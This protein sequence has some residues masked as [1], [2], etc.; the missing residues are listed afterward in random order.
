[1]SAKATKPATDEKAEEEETK[2]EF[3]DLPGVGAT[4]AEK[5]R[6]AGYGDMMELAVASPDDIAAAADIGEGIAQ[7]IIVEARKRAKVG[8]FESGTDI[9]ERRKRIG[10]VTTM[11]KNLDELLG[12]GIETQAITEVYGA[13]GSGKCTHPGTPVLY[14]NDSVAHLEPI[15]EIYAKYAAKFGEIPFD[16][17]WAVPVD[18]VQVAGLTESGVQRVRASHL[19]R[20]KVARL[21][22]IKTARGRTL[23]ITPPHKLV[24]ITTEGVSWVPAAKLAPGC[25][26]ATPRTLQAR[27][28]ED[29]PN[30]VDEDDAFFLGLY[31]SEG[32]PIGITNTD[33]R[34]IKWVE[35]YIEG[36][37]GHSPRVSVGHGRPLPAFRVLL[38]KPVRTFL[39]DLATQRSATKR[40]PASVLGGSDGVVRSFLAGYIEGDG[41]IQPLHTEVDTASAGLARDV[42]YLFAR[43]GIQSST[44]VRQVK[45]KP[46]WRVSVV[47][48]DRSRI[49]SLPLRF[50][51]WPSTLPYTSA[52]G[53]PTPTI[54][55]LQRIYRQGLG[56]HRGRKQKRVGR[57][58]NRNDRFY[59][60]LVEERTKSDTLNE[61]TFRAIAETFLE[62]RAR[63]ERAQRLTTRLDHLDLREFARLFDL[64]PQAFSAYAERAGISRSVSQNWR[65]RG[66]SP[67]RDLEPL[68]AIM[69]EDLSR[70]ISILS[71]GLAQMKNIHSFAWDIIVSVEHVPY[72]GFVYDLTVPEGH[73]FVAGEMPTI[74]HNTQLALQV[75]S[76]IQLP[77][78]QGGLEG[79]AVWIDTENTFRPERLT[80]MAKAAGLDPAEALKKVHVAHAFNASHQELLVPKAFELARQKPVRLLVVDS[81]TAH[82]RA[83]FLGRGA[84]AERQQ[85]LNRHM[86]ELLRF[87]DVFNAA[88][89]CTNQV[90]S[91]P[92]VLFGDPTG[93][94]GG[95]IVGHTATYRVYM[96]K[97]KPPRR[98]ARLVD[99][100]NLPEGEAIFSVL[101]E[102]I[103]DAG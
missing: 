25:P 79:E 8:G 97:S 93:P 45:G 20:E 11:S 61:A 30:M 98:I 2:V 57:A 21:I 64:L 66:V 50:K 24:S 49:R 51:Q 80:E 84:L 1:M 44:R 63:L 38:R 94:I 68:K 100:P 77:V 42:A 46:Y 33:L 95:N 59:H 16:G 34:L 5:L 26:I 7:K 22:R 36:K 89:I 83:E 56:G 28:A 91:R 29:H 75:S 65:R 14:F 17:G 85:R 40:V 101:P 72:D 53:F 23:E 103:R 73:T 55:V 31:V 3:E 78:D 90:S 43:I 88:I 15:G 81:L 67:N 47:G 69:T 92:D 37:F 82:F 99:S 13:F 62:G 4:T 52:Y 39:G 76:S 87:G 102:G 12:G 41:C 58:R 10:K 27:S 18:C 70:R 86:H 60:V 96:R 74:M 48:E 54:E 6:E 9:L 19:Y 35:S 71:Q 32:D